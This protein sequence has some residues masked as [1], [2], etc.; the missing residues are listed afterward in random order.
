MVAYDRQNVFR[1]EFTSS[2]VCGSGGS[3]EVSTTASSSYAFLQS[4]P[5]NPD[6][7][8]VVRSSHFAPSEFMLTSPTNA[9]LPARKLQLSCQNGC[10]PPNTNRHVMN[11]EDS[12]G[13]II[14]FC[15]R[16]Q[17][18]VRVFSVL[19]QGTRNSMDLLKKWVS[20]LER[21]HLAFLCVETVGRHCKGSR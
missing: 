9:R 7:C 10:P 2:G 20:C 14:E 15:W 18:G 13:L 11:D 12:P 19:R 6:L 4:F 21:R 8:K 16:A 3:E 5:S 1:P 17:S